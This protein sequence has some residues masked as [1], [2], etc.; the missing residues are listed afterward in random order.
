MLHLS[1]TIEGGGTLLTWQ[2]SHFFTC[3]C[4]YF[5]T[6]TCRPLRVLS[7]GGLSSPRVGANF[8]GGVLCIFLWRQ[9][10]KRISARVTTQLRNKWVAREEV[11]ENIRG[12]VHAAFVDL[13]ANSTP[14][15]LFPSLFLP[16]CKVKY[17]FRCT[18]NKP[19]LMRAS[20]KSQNL[21]EMWW[22]RQKNKEVLQS[23]LH[24]GQHPSC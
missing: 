21:R 5:K 19:S 12:G 13:A 10:K 2:V 8:R 16:L 15:N 24:P 17:I 18:N 22:K 9:K 14:P 23:R 3:M 6:F 20:V 4:S 7:G 11:E 1:L